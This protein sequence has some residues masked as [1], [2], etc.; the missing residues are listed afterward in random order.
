MTTI[1]VKNKLKHDFL[2]ATVIINSMTKSATNF[3]SK[4]TAQI[5]QTNENQKQI[6]KLYYA[7]H[8]VQEQVKKIEDCFS[9]SLDLIN[10]D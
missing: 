10:L 8:A 6:D 7:M 1:E 5:E 3:F 4:L 2:N 9:K